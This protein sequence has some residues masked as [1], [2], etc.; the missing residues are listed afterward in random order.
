MGGL[1][2]DEF[3]GIV[4]GMGHGGGAMGVERRA[5]EQIYLVTLLANKAV[6]AKP[7]EDA[8]VTAWGMVMRPEGRGLSLVLFILASFFISNT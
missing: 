8:Q 1:T 4:K 3:H 5:E 6:P 2:A 7:T